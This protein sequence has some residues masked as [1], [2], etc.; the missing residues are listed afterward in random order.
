VTTWVAFEDSAPLILAQDALVSKL[1]VCCFGRL[2]D[3]AAGW[4]THFALPIAPEG[5]TLFVPYNSLTLLF[6]TC[7]RRLA[8]EPTFP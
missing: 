7:V 5:M 6:M 3:Q 2:A 1:R 8:R 4:H